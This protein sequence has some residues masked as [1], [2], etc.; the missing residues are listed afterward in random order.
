MKGDVLKVGIFGKSGS[1]KT[2]VAN[3]FEQK[4]FYHINL[5]EIGKLVPCKYPE[6]LAEITRVFGDGYVTGCEIDRKKLGTLVFS[7]RSELDKLNSIFFG[8]IVK[9][10]LDLLEEH[11]NCVVEGAV[12]IESGLNEL[13]DRVVYTR[14]SHDLSVQRIMKREGI[15]EKQAASRVSAQSKYDEMEDKSD[16]VI[17]TNDSV[18]ELQAKIEDLFR[19]L[20]I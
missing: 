14:T 6:V 3:F 2:T 1:G 20:N 12:L 10:T 13:M 16:F 19:D 11:E 15:S 5:D 8:F 17:E 7:D 9:E 4:G 18:E